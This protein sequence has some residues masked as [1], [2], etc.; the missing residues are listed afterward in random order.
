MQVAGCACAPDVFD[1]RRWGLPPGAAAD[2]AGRLH[3][4]WKRFHG[5]FTTKTHDTSQYAWYYLK[6]AMTMDGGRDYANIARRVIS[7]DDDGQNLQQFMSDS[8][9]DAKG[10]FYQ[11]QAEVTARAEMAGGVLT[12]DDSGKKRS[13]DHSA[14]A[15]RQYVGREHQV[16]MAQVGVHLGYYQHGVWVV[17][18]AELYLPKNWFD[19]EHTGLR[20]QLHIPEDRLFATKTELGFLMVLRAWANRLPFAIVAFDCWYGRDGKLRAALDAMGELYIAEVPQDTFVYVERPTVAVPEKP[21]G[22]AGPHFQH[23]QVV[24]EAQPVAVRD[25]LA[26]PDLALQPV[27]IRHTERGM[28]TYEC[29]ARPV[30]VLGPDGRPRDEWL[31]IR[32][33][34]D[35]TFS[36]ALSNAPADTP[37]W[38][39]A[40]WR[41]ERYFAERVYEDVKDEAGWGELVARKFRAWMHH[42]AIDALA[43]WFVSETKLDWAKEHPR[44]PELSRELQVD[45]L[46]ALSMANVR[47]L[48]KAALPLPQ[49]TPE[50]A[51]RLVAKHLVNRSRST[52]TRLEAQRR[53]RAAT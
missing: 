37:L 13:G 39:L 17:A 19:E 29:A 40:L 53:T 49:L 11:I 45:V 30:F 35:E 14:G 38:Q 6:A 4:T 24:S 44:D 26:H 31:F 41:C 25:L 10:V 16:V 36:F 50:Q 8:P 7:P 33:E 43:L 12:L 2:A 27:A 5:C 20:R 28:L 18:D 51:S 21:S 34:P 23:P 52:H 46:P 9:W 32:R 47:E 42:T 1:C 3:R 48:L 22:T 15:G